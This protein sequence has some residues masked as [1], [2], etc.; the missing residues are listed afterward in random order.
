MTTKE[1]LE[2]AA[3]RHGGL[4]RMDGYDDCVLGVCTRFGQPPVLVYD[5]EKV[6]AKLMADGMSR[7]EAEEFWEYNQLGA[8]MGETTPAFL[9]ERAPAGEGGA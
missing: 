3:E 1:W 4:L 9:V 2:E 7:E 6:L 5:L 8:W